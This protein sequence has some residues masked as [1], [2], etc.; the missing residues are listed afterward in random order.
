MFAS[1]VIFLSVY[2]CD[3]PS[4]AGVPTV[5][6]EYFRNRFINYLCKCHLFSLYVALAGTRVGLGTSPACSCQKIIG[7]TLAAIQRVVCANDAM[8]VVN[9]LGN[10]YPTI[11]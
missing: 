9:S 1:T 5:L 6:A 7:S 11:C 4:G 10:P 3:S 8:G 2:P